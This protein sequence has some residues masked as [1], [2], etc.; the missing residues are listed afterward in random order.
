MATL[1]DYG[2]IDYNVVSDPDALYDA[3]TSIIGICSFPI[4]EENF[5]LDSI[6]MLGY[7]KGFWSKKLKA[8]VRLEFI[9]DAKLDVNL[10]VLQE[11]QSV[12]DHANMLFALTVETE[13]EKFNV[14]GIAKTFELGKSRKQILS[15]GMMI[16]KIE[17][18]HKGFTE[19]QLI[20]MREKTPAEMY[21]GGN[22]NF[23]DR[24]Y[25]AKQESDDLVKAKQKMDFFE[26]FK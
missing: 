17:T 3:I 2:T 21:L 10:L 7:V 14:P 25:L 1:N 5:E 23:S 18:N 26:K 4:T 6:T 20:E 24:F 15:Y 19:M 12:P 8:Y 22:L 11:S 9:K 13:I 16:Q